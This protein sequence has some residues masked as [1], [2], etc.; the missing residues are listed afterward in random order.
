MPGMVRQTVSGVV[1]GIRVYSLPSSLVSPLFTRFSN[2][3]H[4][5]LPFIYQSECTSNCLP[6]ASLVRLAVVT[7]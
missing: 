3:L 1:S 5:A 4:I 7:V 2:G 6:H